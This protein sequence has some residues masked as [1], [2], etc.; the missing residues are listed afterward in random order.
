MQYQE[1]IK[2]TPYKMEN[3]PE[4]TIFEWLPNGDLKVIEINRREVYFKKEEALKTSVQIKNKLEF[5]K[6]E[7]SEENKQKIQR[8]IDML[9]KTSD[10]WKNAIKEQEMKK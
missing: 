2:G 10:Q 5:H 3:F 4:P 7:I 9:Q 8:N 1:K 6:Y